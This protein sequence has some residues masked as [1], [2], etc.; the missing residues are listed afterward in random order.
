MSGA[1]S[2]CTGTDIGTRLRSALRC[3]LDAGF[4]FSIAILALLCK[5]QFS[6]SRAPSSGVLVTL[7]RADTRFSVGIAGS[8]CFSR[9]VH[10]A[11]LAGS[12]RFGLTAASPTFDLI[13]GSFF[14]AAES[15]C[16][17]RR[18]EL[19]KGETRRSLS[20][21]PQLLRDAE[22]KSSLPTIFTVPQVVSKPHF[23]VV[24]GHEGR[25]RLFFWLLRLLLRRLELRHLVRQL[26][27]RSVISGF[28]GGS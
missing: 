7:V 28:A 11:L 16:D 8:L 15:L 5:V 12:A 4:S 2:R 13:S 19:V 14:L 24:V 18:D 26:R 1:A 23:K 9:K 20:T 27:Y 25:R 22:C 6:I 21:F 10:V 17:F 3:G